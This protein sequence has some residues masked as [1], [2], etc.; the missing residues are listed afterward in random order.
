MPETFEAR[1]NIQISEKC[2]LKGEMLT[3]DIYPEVREGFDTTLEKI[4][5]H[6]RLMS[7][8]GC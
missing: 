7:N 4:N 8:K 6:K 3:S 5:T 1:A 2:I